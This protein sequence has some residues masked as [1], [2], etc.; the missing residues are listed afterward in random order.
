VQVLGILLI[1]PLAV[2]MIRRDFQLRGFDRKWFVD[3]VQFGHPFIYARR[4]L[5]P[6]FLVLW[7]AGCWHQ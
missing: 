5:D 4:D 1:A 6:G 3:L 2:W 7:I